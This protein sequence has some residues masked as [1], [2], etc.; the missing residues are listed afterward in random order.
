MKKLRRKLSKSSRSDTNLPNVSLLTRVDN[1]DSLLL[2]SPLFHW[3]AKGVTK[4]T[5]KVT[6][7]VI[8]LLVRIFSSERNELFGVF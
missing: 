3:A 8:L 4:V 7:E 5:P 2:Q 6:S 1:S